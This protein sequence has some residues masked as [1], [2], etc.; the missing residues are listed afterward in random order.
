MS[1]ELTVNYLIC[2]LAV[3]QWLVMPVIYF[4]DLN[5]GMTFE[6]TKM[7]VGSDEYFNFAFKSTMA[8]C[9]GLLFF[10]I[11]ENKLF[12]LIENLKSDL[13][14]KEML[15]L[16]LVLISFFFDIFKLIA[17]LYL[18]QYIFFLGYLKYMGIGLLSINYFLNRRKKTLI[19]LLISITLVMVSAIKQLMFGELVFGF[20]LIILTMTPFIKP[21]LKVRLLSIFSLSLL[22]IF[23]QLV[24]PVA[25]SY[26]W[27]SPN[28]TYIGLVNEISDNKIISLD[29]VKS[30]GFIGY[31]I[32][33]FNQGSIISWTMKKVPRNIPF[34]KG[35]TVLS[36]A[37]GSFIPRFIWPSKPLK[38]TEMYKKYTG[39]DVKGASF[40]IS[41]LGESYINFGI[42]GSL[43]FMLILGFIYNIIQNKITLRAI[44]KPAFFFILPILFLHGIKVETDLTRSLGFIFRFY[45]FLYFINLILNKVFNRSLY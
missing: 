4:S 21:S 5:P 26:M 41:Q 7:Q 12:E 40:G 32:A 34:E 27:R 42:K 29:N 19:H 28:P 25:R 30:E 15:G 6:I 39:L 1:N 13:I 10:K 11:K 22:V 17:P 16:N 2:I 43:Y 35:K 24:K 38:G 44:Y 33:R 14:N 23:I 45:I 9:F 31:S 18:K 3:F 37:L 8:F 36:A 20:A